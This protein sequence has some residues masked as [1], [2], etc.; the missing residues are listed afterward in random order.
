MAV[1]AYVRAL[2]PAPFN[3]GGAGIKD[4]RWNNDKPVGTPDTIT[5]SFMTVK[6]NHAGSDG[7]GFG[8]LTAAQKDA[9]RDIF[10]LY[11]EVSGITFIEMEGTGTRNANAEL[12]LGRNTNSPAGYAY[13]P[14]LLKPADN[15]D[16]GPGGD[17]WISRV[18]SATFNLEVAP[19]EA[20]WQTLIHEIGHALGLKHPGIFGPGDKPPV[21]P[22]ST[23]SQQYTVMSYVAAP[24]SRFMQVVNLGTAEE[25]VVYTNVGA[26]T[27]MLYDIAAIQHLYGAN[28]TTRTGDD[29]YAFD[30]DTPFFRCIWDAG[31]T[32]VIDVNN[33]EL[34]CKID[35]N[36]GKFS[37]I[38]IVSDELPTFANGGFYD[39]T[40][41]P[42][43]TYDGTNNLSIAFGAVIENAIGGSGDDRL[44]GNKVANVLTGSDGNDSLTGGAGADSM[45]GGEGDD[46]YT[47]DGADTITE[48]ADGGFDTMLAKVTVTL[49]A[50]VEDLVLTGD[51]N[52]NGT[53]NDDDNTI[54]GNKMKNSLAGMG[55]DD[56]LNG[57]EGN[58]LLDGNDGADSLMGGAGKDTLVWDAL[59]ALLDGGGGADTLRIAAGNLD[60]MAIADALIVSVEQV[61]LT[62]GS[63]NM[64]TVSEADVLAMS[65][66]TKTLKISGEIG[67]TLDIVEALP[68]E[69]PPVVN[70]FRT[71]TVGTAT[72]VVDADL[73]VI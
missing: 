64:L 67:D 20:G 47:A 5:Y 36:G 30:P 12:L 72:L 41:S 16:G 29:V 71:F 24:H 48:A 59:D 15:V 3:T 73:A 70:G 21:L 63:A 58:D 9:A 65:P 7:N 61:D 28:M 68:P 37:S 1:P 8:Q 66:V 17:I 26:S 13:F 44:T 23:N 52:V 2:L 32:D 6:P 27:P 42:L 54:T 50:N 22:N 51:G 14:E 40:G 18:P 46:I 53:G 43:P 19:G 34:G 49:A 39:W 35:L 45:D 31:G 56:T 33:F 60:L 25:D 62:G 38:R 69:L 11:Q 55:G 4:F 57:G 10:A